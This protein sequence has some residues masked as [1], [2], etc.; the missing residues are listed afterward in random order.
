MLALS[1][2]EPRDGW[3]CLSGVVALVQSLPAGNGHTSIPTAWP[4]HSRVFSD[5]GQTCPRQA[6]LRGPGH[7]AM[8]AFHFHLGRMFLL[9]M[10]SRPL[11]AQPCAP[12]EPLTWGRRCQASPRHHP[13]LHSVR[14]GDTPCSPTLATPRAV[15]SA[16]DTLSFSPLVPPTPPH[17]PQKLSWSLPQGSPPVARLPRGSRNAVLSRAGPDAAS[18]MGNTSG[19]GTLGPHVLRPSRPLGD[20][21]SFPAAGS[22]ETPTGRRRGTD[23]RHRAGWTFFQGLVN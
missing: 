8:R 13:V 21:C 14:S 18:A 1:G 9:G 16:G 6:G 23:V 19:P 20:G 2:A 4:G 5:A 22:G 17:P 15:P 11:W 7:L 12:F 10:R 3:V